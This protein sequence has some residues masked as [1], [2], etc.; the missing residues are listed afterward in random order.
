MARITVLGGTGYAGS[1]IVREAAARGHE[2]VA[3]SRKAADEAIDGVVS[4]TGSAQS[5]ADLERATAGAEVIVV[6]LAPSGE[7][8]DGFV[9]LNAEIA[10]LA[11]SR[12]ARLGVVGGAGS[13]LLTAD[14]PVVYEAPE[15][16]EQFRGY[17]RIGDTVLQA[18]RGSDPGLDWFVLSPPRGFGHYAPGEATG[19]FRVGGEV[20][21]TDEQGRSEIS[22]ADF[23]TAFVDEIERPVHRRARFTVA[24]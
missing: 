2:V 7:L 9:E 16:P 12:G 22:G 5:R 18:L 17:A 13:L 11:R 4:V 23:A 8:Q 24:Y 6:A 10:E 15:F 21:L 20:M 19:T 1:A 3:F 14:G